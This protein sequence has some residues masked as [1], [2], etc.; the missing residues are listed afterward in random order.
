MFFSVTHDCNAKFTLSAPVILISG[1]IAHANCCAIFV[2]ALG[3]C[4]CA[5]SVRGEVFGGTSIPKSSKRE[6]SSDAW[7][8]RSSSSSSLD[9]IY[10]FFSSSSSARFVRLDALS[11][12]LSLSLCALL[13]RVEVCARFYLVRAISFV[14]FPQKEKI[15]TRIINRI[16]FPLLLWEAQ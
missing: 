6:R 7:R 14:T 2:N 15:S 1:P 3:W 4:L 9:G 5:R 13:S 10:I 8:S 16:V 11:L 12:S